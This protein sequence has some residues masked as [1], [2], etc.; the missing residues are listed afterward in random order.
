LK[1]VNVDGRLLRVAVFVPGLHVRRA[2][3]RRDV[4]PHRARVVVV[5][6][7]NASGANLL[8]LFQRHTDQSHGQHGR[9][10][11]DEQQ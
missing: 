9:Q 10:S 1:I 11:G 4:E 3:Q 7:G 8:N 2:T 6:V 5:V